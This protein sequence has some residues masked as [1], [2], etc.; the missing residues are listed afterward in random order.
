MTVANVLSL[1]TSTSIIKISAVVNTQLPLETGVKVV[2]GTKSSS[3]ITAY[4]SR[5]ISE[6]LYKPDSNTYFI[7]VM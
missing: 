3:A 2:E 7:L 4:N 6:Y 1:A 5:T